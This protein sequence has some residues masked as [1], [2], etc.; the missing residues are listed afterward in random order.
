MDLLDPHFPRKCGV[1]SEQHQFFVITAYSRWP[2][3]A[4]FEAAGAVA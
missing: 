3:F 1:A 4:Q 2:G